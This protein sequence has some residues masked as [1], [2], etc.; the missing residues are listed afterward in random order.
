MATLPTKHA[1]TSTP[2]HEPSSST[3]MESHSDRKK[4]HEK[5]KEHTATTRGDPAYHSLSSHSSSSSSS[6]FSDSAK[7]NPKKPIGDAAKLIATPTI[8]LPNNKE[9]PDLPVLTLV[10]QL[11]RETLKYRNY[12]LVKR[13]TRYSYPIAGKSSKWQTKLKV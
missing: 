13:S 10:N 3:N 2:R 4:Q 5:E 8:K 11:Y 12:R 6:S 9:H 1:C 7:H